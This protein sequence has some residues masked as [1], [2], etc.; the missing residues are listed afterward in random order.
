MDLKVAAIMTYLK[1]RTWAAFLI[2][3]LP[4]SG[5]N[6]RCWFNLTNS[7]ADSQGNM[8]T[9]AGTPW[10]ESYQSLL[11]FEYGDSRKSKYYYT[12]STF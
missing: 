4:F 12:Q 6:G 11:Y 1:Q 2:T 9:S 10:T 5:G 7:N 3:A 8:A